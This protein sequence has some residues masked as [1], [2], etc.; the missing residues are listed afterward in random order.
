M[1]G[2]LSKPGGIFLS[3]G[4]H[5]VIVLKNDTNEVVV[6]TTIYTVVAGDNLT[7]IAAKFHTTVDTLVKTN[8]IKNPNDIDIGQKL[9]IK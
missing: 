5:V 9:V 7:K 1:S 6:K 4:H 8:D 2:K 3:E